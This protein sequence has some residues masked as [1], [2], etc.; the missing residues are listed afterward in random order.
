[1]ILRDATRQ[2]RLDEAAWKQVGRTIARIMEFLFL[3]DMTQ[4]VWTVIGKESPKH[5]GPAFDFVSK[6]EPPGRAMALLRRAV[7]IYLEHK[8][9]M[10]SQEAMR[11]VVVQNLALRRKAW[12]ENGARVISYRVMRFLMHS[13]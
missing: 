5:V 11:E 6:H 4:H 8:N 1:M 13:H 3:R 10:K 9:P 7:L 12:A 2:V